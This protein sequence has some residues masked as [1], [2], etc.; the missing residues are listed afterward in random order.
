[1]FLTLAYNVQG[2][3]IFY[4]AITPNYSLCKF[5]HS[6]QLATCYLICLH[7]SVRTDWSLDNSQAVGPLPKSQ[8]S[9]YQSIDLGVFDSGGR[10]L[11]GH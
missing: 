1:M 4:V 7:Y 10:C 3:F 9:I 2:G 8:S 6:T 5:R 11:M